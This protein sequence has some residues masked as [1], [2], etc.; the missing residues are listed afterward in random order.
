MKDHALIHD[1]SRTNR[2]KHVQIKKKISKLET[3]Q[4][5]LIVSIGQS[6]FLY[7]S[8]Q[9]KLSRSLKSQVD[10][11]EE[12]TTNDQVIVSTHT[13]TCAFFPFEYRVNENTCA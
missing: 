6:V 2:L 5:K 11:I 4:R 3:H 1:L 10:Y 9:K 7:I 8:E 13:F 12:S